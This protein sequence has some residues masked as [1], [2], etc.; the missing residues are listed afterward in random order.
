MSTLKKFFFVLAGGLVL[1][2]AVAA[3]TLDTISFG[4]TTSERSHAL[5]Q[6]RSEV[7][8]GGL[9][10]SARQL[11]PLNPVSY[12]GGS[13]SFTLAVDPTNQNYFTV[14]LWG[15]D[16]GEE[17]GRLLLYLDGQQVGYRHEGDHDVLNQ[18]DA[19]AI[20]QG[21][22]LY[23]TVAL[24]P[25]LTRGKAN[26]SLKIAALGPIYFYGSTFEKQQKLLTQ[27]SRGIY[28]AYMHTNTFFEPGASEKPGE[29]LAPKIRPGGPG[30]EL[31]EQTRKTVNERLTH[32]MQSKTFSGDQRT[33]EG[34]ILLLAEAYNTPWTTAYHNPR[35]IEALVRG[36]DSFMRPG[37]IG[38]SWVAAGPL[39]E[40]I[41]RVG[42]EPLK[43]F[44]DEEIEVPQNFPFL[45]D[46]RRHEPLEEPNI[47]TA[48]VAN[49]KIKTK[50][51][52]AWAKVLRA[53]VDWNRKNGRRFYTNQSMIVD[54]NIYTANRGLD[55]LDGSQA[56]PS[57][58]AMRYLYEATGLQPWLGNDTDDGGSSK[59]YGTNYL[60]ITRKGLSRELGYVG[61]YGETILKFMREMA[62][63]TGDEKIRQQ[64]IRVET[65]RVNFRYPSLD[66]DG[67]QQMKLVSEIDARTAHF[68]AAF[69]AY[70]I[71]SINEAW[72]MELPAFLKDPV[73]VGAAQQC[74]E[75]NQ[76]FYRLDSRAND[77]DT[78]GM[79]RNIDEYTAVKKLPPSNFRLPMTDG[80]P[81][82]VFSDEE[83]AVVAVKHGDERLFLNFY[84]RQEFG[85]SGVVRI[86]DVQTNIMRIASVKSEFE[87]EPSGET[88]TRPDI[89][90]FERSGGMPPPGEAVHQA[91][92]GETLP[93]AKRPGDASHPKYGTWGPF[94]G[95][96]SFY[97]L[98]YGSYLFAINT[99]ADKTY[100]LKTPEDI[101]EA[102]ELV[103]HKAVKLNSPLKVGPYSTVVLW[104]NGK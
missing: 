86:L 33:A 27:P 20:F 52:D 93:I 38:N 46:W 63:L 77:K 97:T 82:Y 81:D 3:V 37:V 31:I 23:Q 58:Q 32:I 34:E 79:M 99:T 101:S 39:G 19:E 1:T 30:E 67:Y 53:S 21:R 66:A 84:F 65:A 7:I 6:V 24:P 4:D 9:G 98:R 104:L 76:Y 16:K 95:K 29:Y 8:H 75:E 13:V 43:T 51:R 56:L 47:K 89:I 102:R 55:L 40:A 60:Q 26:I 22:F 2:R 71:P 12:N 50:R 57:M 61:T 68:P 88:W 91:W 44:L 62:E 69:G 83:N 85:V 90:D 73:S 15:S 64:L 92:R 72:W 103:S 11:L 74:L 54:R 87:V 94:V 45:P 100:E 78:L 17:R 80:Q 48:K 18:C 70:A 14:K 59:P 10:E 35:A 28:C 49:S 41:L 96:A 36:G 25:M 5:E 42:T